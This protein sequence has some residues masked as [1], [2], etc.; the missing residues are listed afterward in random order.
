[1]ENYLADAEKSRTIKMCEISLYLL[2]NK[3]ANIAHLRNIEFPPEYSISAILN[4]AAQ[5]W[6]TGMAFLAKTEPGN[7]N[8]QYQ[9]V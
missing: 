9:I 1:M 3:E 7:K 2:K 5:E 6:R 8:G 4:M